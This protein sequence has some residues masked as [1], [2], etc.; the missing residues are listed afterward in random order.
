MRPA[1]VISVIVTPWPRLRRCAPAAFTLI[2]LLVVVAVIV[3]LIAI[4]L[5]SLGRARE[6]ARTVHCQ[7]GLRQWGFALTYY[8][9]DHNQFL[10]GEGSSGGNTT[11]GTWYNELPPYAN[12]PRYGDIYTGAA[13][14]SDAG[15]KNSWIWYCQTRLLKLKNASSGKNSFHYA[16][17]GVL[18]GAGNWGGDAGVVHNKVAAMEEPGR[19]VFLMEPAGNVPNDTPTDHPTTSATCDN[20]DLA[21]H[22]G[23]TNM[24]FVDAHVEN[25]KSVDL[26]VPKL[27]AGIYISSSPRMIWGPLPSSE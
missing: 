26:P 17:N 10:P 24:L 5:P 6:T 21:R 15:Y 16:M 8:L 12:A 7:S 25:V 27:V 20:L 13:L 1:P 14:A 23:S 4:M 19:T 18:D 2:E 9:N 3:V 22:N 11:P